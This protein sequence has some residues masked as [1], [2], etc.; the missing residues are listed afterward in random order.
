MPA[1][2]KHRC[3]VAVCQVCASAGTGYGVG[4]SDTHGILVALAGVRRL[5]VVH[6]VVAEV[7]GRSG[8]AGGLGGPRTD[9][10]RCCDLSACWP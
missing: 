9:D 6:G 10:R 3:G 8:E 5:P 1:L 4:T 7:E 2:G